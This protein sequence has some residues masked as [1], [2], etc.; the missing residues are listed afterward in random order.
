MRK[1]RELLI[2]YESRL[3]LS[4]AG[5]KRWFWA[6]FILLLVYVECVVYA[7][8]TVYDRNTPIFSFVYALLAVPFCFAAVLGCSRLRLAPAAGR[9]TLR[10]CLLLCGT[11]FC[12]S[13]VWFFLWQRAY[14]PGCF[15][16]DSINQLDQVINGSYNDWHPV[17]HTWLFFWLPYRF[18]QGPAIIVLWQNLLFSLAIAYY[19][20]VLYRNGCPRGFLFFAWL[21][22]VANPNNCNIMLFP[23]KDS[24]L[25]IFALVLFAQ[26]IQIYA[27]RGRWMKRWSNLAAFTIVI[28]LSL[29]MRHNAALMLLPL[30]VILAV[31]IPGIKKKLLLSV[32][33]VLAATITLRG[34][35]YAAAD[36]K[37]AGYRTVEISSMLMAMLSN[38]YLNAP[39]DLSPEAL[40]FMESLAPFEKYDA[41]YELGD[42]CSVKYT[43]PGIFDAIEE[44]GLAK[45]FRYTVDAAVKHP[46]CAWDA[47]VQGTNMVWIVDG[48]MQW[49]R[50]TGIAPAYHAAE[51][52]VVSHDGNP[53]L[54]YELSNYADN[55][56]NYVTKYIF[57]YVGVLNLFLLTLAVS[58]LGGRREREREGSWSAVLLV[59]SPIA[60][61]FGSVLMQPTLSEYR[62]YH[63]NFLTVVPL[64]FII[65]MSSTWNQEPDRAQH[66]CIKDGGKTHD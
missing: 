17:L 18:Y 57:D 55:C 12:L 58:K 46:G 22:I 66:C 38:V 33:V 20:S 31:F 60:Y 40:E 16:P 14:W 9:R 4:S 41:E 61:N 3:G 47:F 1:I 13:F 2:Q 36:V 34:P 64:V 37:P 29:N 52:G 65:L 27:T 25:S 15:S 11:V 49:G 6:C 8:N 26:L 24:A 7:Q 35:I 39:Q 59:L 42:F 32:T 56:S 43:I 19:V 51:L 45:I 28:F 48:D 50:Y 5:E 63:F 10:R 23:W 30:L 53:A 62:Y 54:R 21:Y 44:E